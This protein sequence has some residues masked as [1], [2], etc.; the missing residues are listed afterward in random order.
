MLADGTYA[1][2][3]QVGWIRVDV[4]GDGLHELV[5]LGDMV[6][7]R[8]PGTVYDVFGEVP[9]ETPIEKQRVFVQGNIYKGWDAIPDAY[10]GPTSIMDPSY[11]RGT[12]L[13]TLKF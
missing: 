9:E 13:G 1:E 2:I 7:E 10:K 5:A 4:D 11:Y 6:G 12:T 3:L 8:P